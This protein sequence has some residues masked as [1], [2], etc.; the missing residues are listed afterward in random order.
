MEAYS[1]DDKPVIMTMANAIPRVPDEDPS[2][3][4]A[5]CFA[6]PTKIDRFVL[7]AREFEWV[8]LKRLHLYPSSPNKH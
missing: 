6:D 8:R 4:H 7:E 2:N 1:K 3:L 5:T